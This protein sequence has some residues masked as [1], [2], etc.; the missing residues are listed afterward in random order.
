MKTHNETSGETEQDSPTMDRRHF[1]RNAVAL[2]VV[3]GTAGIASAAKEVET[4]DVTG[5]YANIQKTA[6]ECVSAGAVCIDHCLE[7][8]AAGDTSLA[9]CARTVQEMLPICETGA[10]LAAY[11]S[12]F[13]PQYVAVCI[14]I[15]AA[16]EKEC[17]KHEH[18]HVQCKN[19]ADACAACIA[20]CKKIAA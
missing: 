11:E 5:K 6:L 13:M 4:H 9:A 10:K 15:C 19:C 17:R 2:G 18:H 14:E 3:A 7:G 1:I 12:K 8:F 16:C 20:E